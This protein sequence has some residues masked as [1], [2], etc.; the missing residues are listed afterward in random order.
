[1]AGLW[2]RSDAFVDEVYDFFDVVGM[3]PIHR[4]V[5]LE[6]RELLAHVAS[7]VS[8]DA[9]HGFVKRPC[10]VEIVEKFL[11]SHSVERVEVA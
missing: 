7:G 10:P 9:F 2:L 6:P 11:V 3:E 5:A 8:F 1:M 4:R